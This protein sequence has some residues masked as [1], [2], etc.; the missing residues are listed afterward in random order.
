MRLAQLQRMAPARD[1]LLIK[2]GAAKHQSP[3]AWRLVRVDVAADG[4][5]DYALRK[6]KLRE[7]IR[8][9][10]SYL[11]RSNLSAQDPARIWRLYMLLVQ[12]EQSFK[13]LKGDLAVRPIYHQL[14]HRIEAHIFVAFLAFC[15]HATMRHKL[16]LKAPGL[17]PRSLIE[18]LS[19]IQM[20]DVHF[21][22]TDGRTLIFKRYTMPNKTQKLLLAQLGLQLPKQSPPRITSQ[23]TLQP[24]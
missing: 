13:D 9:E 14:E 23:K 24:S 4:T 17:T 8:R 7:V 1:A 11:L 22:T 3:P 2:L 19:A 21:P 5:L 15:L 6:D 16:Q 18:Q 10:G 20:L 12:V